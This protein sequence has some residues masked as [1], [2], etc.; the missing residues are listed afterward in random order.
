MSLILSIETSSKNCSVALHESGMLVAEEEVLLER[1]HS[2]QI[3]VL[4][5]K[6]LKD[7]TS[8]KSLSAI[9]V[10]KG[11]GSYTGLRIGVSTAKGLCYALD[12]PL[13]AVNT[14]QIIAA[15]INEGS[16]PEK[17]LVCPMM[18][19]RRMEVYTA[20]FDEKNN[21]I[22]QTEPKVLDG[23]F[24]KDVLEGRKIIFAGDG[25]E[26]FKPFVSS[27]TNALFA[28][29]IFPSAR[30]MGTL[31]FEFFLKRQFEDIA[32]FEPY[33]LKEFYTKPL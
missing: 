13:I 12:L 9:A 22:S 32:Y 14:L 31:S 8:G 4:I 24:H 6:I 21:F 26:K 25:A 20:L 1:S 3:T 18:D 23:E 15:G 16:N 11:P 27:Q 30:F 28:D 29:G 19:A 33:Y 17:Y 5:E 10:S 2:E 7:H